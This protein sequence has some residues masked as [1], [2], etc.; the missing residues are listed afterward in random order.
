MA[1]GDIGLHRL[2][3]DEVTTGPRR[4]SG[5]PQGKAAFAPSQIVGN[6]VNQRMVVAV[7]E[8]GRP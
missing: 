6:N 7:L 8:E 4:W 3:G 1:D 5:K 2:D